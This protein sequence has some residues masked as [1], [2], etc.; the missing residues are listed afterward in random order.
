M[1]KQSPRL[2]Q[3]VA[4]VPEGE[5]HHRCDHPQRRLFADHRYRQGPGGAM[6]PGA[7]RRQRQPPHPHPLF[8]PMPGQV[9]TIA[10]EHF[11][12]GFIAGDDKGNI[13]IYYATSQR[14]VL[15]RST[16][17]EAV[18]VVGFSPRANAVLVES[19]G[20]TIQAARVDND[21]PE[22]SFS[23]LWQKVWYESYQEPEYNWQSSAA[24]PTSNPSSASRR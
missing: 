10:P 9:T 17:S 16:G 4:V 24:T 12:K 22:I 11:R 15:E 18:R 6:V 2:V 7:R 8:K 1:D 3:T 14:L 13:G 23:S 20:G 21:Y 5:T 19:A